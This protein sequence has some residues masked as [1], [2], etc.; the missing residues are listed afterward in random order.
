HTV[1]EAELVGMVFAVQLLREGGGRR[2][3]TMSLGVDNQAAIRA[4]EVFRSK[5]GHCL[6]DIFHDDLRCLIPYDDNRKLTIRWTP[7]HV[8]IMGNEEA[9]EHAKRVARGETSD[10]RELPKSL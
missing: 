4:R 5:P 2:G 10:T 3:G 6:M 8:N 1:Y 7:G 9:D